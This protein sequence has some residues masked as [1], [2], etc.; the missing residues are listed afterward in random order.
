MAGGEDVRPLPLLAR[1]ARLQALLEDAGQGLRFSEHMEGPVGEA[2]F[3]H[4]CRLGLEVIVSTKPTAPYL[5][6]RRSSWLK[7]K[8][9]SYER[10]G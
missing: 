9:P 4:A 2:M 1:R 5:S 3:R 6:G 10:R 8:N 7:I